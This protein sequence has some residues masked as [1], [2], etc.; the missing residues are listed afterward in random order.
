M[1]RLWLVLALISSAAWANPQSADFHYSQSLTTQSGSAQYQLSLP[2]AVYQHSQR[3][4]LGDVRVFNADGELVP[5]TLRTPPAIAPATQWIALPLFPQ[6]EAKNTDGSHTQIQRN[7]DGSLIQI[8][9][10]ALQTNITSFLLDKSQLKKPINAIRFAWQNSDYS[11][12]VLIEASDDLQVWREIQRGTVLSLQFQGQQ[13]AQQ[14]LE[15]PQTSAKYLRLHWPDGAPQLR[16]VQVGLVT[17][18]AIQAHEWQTASI[19]QTESGALYF[20]T[21]IATPIDQMRVTL[22]QVNTIVRATLSS[23][24]RSD[25]AWLARWQGV[26]YRIAKNN[27][28][29]SNTPAMFSPNSHIEWKLQ[30]DTQG[31]GIGNGPAKIEMGWTPST[32]IFVARGNPPFTVAYG[33]KNIRSAAQSETDLLITPESAIANAST[34]S[35]VLN[36]NPTTQGDATQQKKWLLWGAL[37]LAVGILAV[38]ARSLIQQLKRSQQ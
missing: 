17:A 6:T 37:I 24:P 4:D 3:S 33:N 19:S 29:I 8:T 38:M 13:L 11:G 18:Q 15:L 34:A 31:G 25:A 10:Q 36:P 27:N 26:L 30:I 5:Y 7:A 9:Q 23:R 14:M 21:D 12:G 1:M 35:A 2:L 28:E 32:L 20:S 22:P 16:E